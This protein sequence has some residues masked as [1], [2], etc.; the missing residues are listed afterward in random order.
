MTKI[1][2][3][4]FVKFRMPGLTSETEPKWSSLD[5]WTLRTWNCGDGWWWLKSRRN[6]MEVPWFAPGFSVSCCYCCE[7]WWSFTILSIYL[8]EM[9][10]S[11]VSIQ[12][13]TDSQLGKWITCGGHWPGRRS[14]ETT[15]FYRDPC[16]F[17]TEAPKSASWT[18][19]M[20]YPSPCVHI[21]LYSFI[22]IHIHSYIDL[23]IC[24][25]IY[26]WIHLSRH[27]RHRAG[28][29][30]LHALQAGQGWFLFSPSHLPSGNQIWQWKMDRLYL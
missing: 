13:S 8:K 17:Q 15:S 30:Q 6:V 14:V 9:L 10:C 20:I 4:N 3:Q 21:Y 18:G 1:P 25:S 27:S 12:R 23:S 5:F 22:F 26:I 7:K 28:E 11:C 19:Y 29:L 24:L 16:F 2:L